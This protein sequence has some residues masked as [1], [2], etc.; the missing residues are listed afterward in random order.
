MEDKTEPPSGKEL[1]SEIAFCNEYYSNLLG[2][3]P[4]QTGLKIL[5][6]Q[7]NSFCERVGLDSNSSGVYLPRN[8][9]AFI[10]G[11]NPLSLFHEYFGHGLF[12]ERTQTGQ[13]LVA[14]EKDLLKEEEQYF[15]E[16]EFTLEQLND[17]RL[18]NCAHQRLQD[19][20][21]E[22]LKLYEIFAIWTTCNLARVNGMNINDG[23]VAPV[24]DFQKKY[25]DLETFY[26][27]GFS[28]SQSENFIQMKGGI[29]R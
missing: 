15:Q 11:E 7:W 16:R 27:F 1:E 13:K 21:R 4:E 8:Q 18:S 5:D 6:G 3:K 25:G 10:R 20:I 19:W 29:K 26:A 14:L 12:C 22:H 9:T 2:Y 17:F 28:H 23:R 24:I